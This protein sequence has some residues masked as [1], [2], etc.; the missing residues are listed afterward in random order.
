M[1]AYPRSEFLRLEFVTKI[2]D[3][4]RLVVL[5]AKIDGLARSAFGTASRDNESAVRVPDIKGR[6]VVGRGA[7]RQI[8]CIWNSPAL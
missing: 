3:A 6:Q 4:L 1:S 8:V 7:F 5:D 2:E